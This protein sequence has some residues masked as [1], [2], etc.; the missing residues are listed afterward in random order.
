MTI[1]WREFYCGIQCVFAGIKIF[2]SDRQLW[3]YSLLPLSAVII[4]YLLLG[5]GAVRLCGIWT[6]Y[7]KSV[8]QELPGFLQWLSSLLG[9]VSALAVT[10]IFLLVIIFTVGTLYELFGGSFFDY[11]INHWEREHNHACLPENS[12]QFELRSLVG[13]IFY[14]LGTLIW[15]L[16]TLLL[17]LLLPVI[18]PLI[19]I[20]II[21]IRLG[22]SYLAPSGFRHGWTKKE[23]HLLT[24]RHRGALLGYGL[25]IYVLFMVPL[26]VLL[27]L[28]GIIIGGNILFNYCRNCDVANT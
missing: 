7:L 24:A 22:F 25:V 17:G 16:I 6:E 28:P 20:I 8:L 18:G 15:M 3:K 13:M 23:I 21:S 4:C 14:S 9:G 11:M 10:G 12:W 5:Y 19:G 26:A 2:Y 1:F 27:V